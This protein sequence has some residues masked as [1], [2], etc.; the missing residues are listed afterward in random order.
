LQVQLD[1][2]EKQY[3]HKRV[4]GVVLEEL[5]HLEMSKDAPHKILH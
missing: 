3:K 2:A 4:V 1:N 5:G